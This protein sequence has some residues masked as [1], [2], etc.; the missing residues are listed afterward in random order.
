V[1]LLA[2]DTPFVT[3][4]LVRNL[5]ARCTPEEAA[6]VAGEG[7]R[8]QPLIA[9]YPSDLLRRALGS[10]GGTAGASMTA[11]MERVTHTLIRDERAARDCDT[12]DDVE[13]ARRMEAGTSSS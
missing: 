6:L 9:A 5:V 10:M 3:A 2:V 1:V 13:L 8:P 4:D 11:L 7:G 12:W